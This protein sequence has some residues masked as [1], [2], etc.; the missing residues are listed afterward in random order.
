MGEK[1]GC[2]AESC[3]RACR[4]THPKARN[5]PPPEAK[6]GPEQL[7]AY[8]QAKALRLWESFI[9]TAMGSGLYRW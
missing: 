4:K 1:A 2:Q 5:L 9:L 7:W 8:R 3:V 6:D